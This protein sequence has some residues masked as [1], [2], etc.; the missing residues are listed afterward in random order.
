MCMQGLGTARNSQSTH[1]SQVGA[2]LHSMERYT[3]GSVDTP[4][5]PAAAHMLHVFMVARHTRVKQN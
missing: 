3:N 1:E 4:S 5:P 2:V